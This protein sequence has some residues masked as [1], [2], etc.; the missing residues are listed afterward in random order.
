M[1]CAE[2]WNMNLSGGFFVFVFGVCDWHDVRMRN[3]PGTPGVKPQSVP[4]PPGIVTNVYPYPGYCVT[5]LQNSQ[6]IRV[7][8]WICYRTYR[9]SGYGYWSVTDRY[10]KTRYPLAFNIQCIILFDLR[11]GLVPSI[12]QGI[13]LHVTFFWLLYMY[14]RNIFLF[15]ILLSC[16]DSFAALQQ[17]SIETA[18]PG[19]YFFYCLYTILR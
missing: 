8:V 18:V 1:S 13:K 12:Y 2:K 3:I 10:Q 7:R 11:G 15:H 4:L 6:K 16:S 9:T 14:R 19:I 17:S 5:V